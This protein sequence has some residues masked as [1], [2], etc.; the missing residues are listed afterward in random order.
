MITLLH[1]NLHDAIMVGKKKTTDIQFYTEVRVFPTR[2][3]R[4][5]CQGVHAEQCTLLPF[6]LAQLL[7][8]V[9]PAAGGAGDGLS[10]D[11]GRRPTVDVRPGR[12]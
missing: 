8:T 4:N 3:C 11:S 12:D 10:A 5:C 6:W 9:S 2:W 1:F 7:S